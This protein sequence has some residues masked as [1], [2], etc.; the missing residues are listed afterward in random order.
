M[1]G[2]G[3]KGLN[4][5][6]SPPFLA[7]F[8]NNVR[9]PD[10]SFFVSFS[11][12]NRQQLLRNRKERRG[13]RASGGGGTG[14]KDPINNSGLAIGKGWRGSPEKREGKKG[15][16]LPPTGVRRGS[17]THFSEQSLRWACV[18]HP[19]NGEIYLNKNNLV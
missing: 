8:T 10:S 14:R 16:V 13:D 2:G 9:R 11:S 4:P 15:A 7:S 12:R 18:G 5:F 1:E 3:R 17:R 19:K 6:P